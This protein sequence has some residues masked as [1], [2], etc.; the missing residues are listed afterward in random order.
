VDCALALLGRPGEIL[1]D[2][3]SD[4]SLMKLGSLM[5]GELR[6]I[7]NIVVEGRGSSSDFD[8][9]LLA[10]AMYLQAL[11]IMHLARSGF[12]VRS[13]AGGEVGLTQVDPDQILAL[14]TKMTLDVAFPQNS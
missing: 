5:S 3:I 6:R 13:E 9:D 7:A 10:N 12:V 1:L 2:E 8:A 14:M 11:G 4:S